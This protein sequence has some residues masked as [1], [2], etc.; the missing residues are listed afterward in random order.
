MAAASL[1]WPAP[2]AKGPGQ[3][4]HY[5]TQKPAGSAADVEAKGTYADGK[6]TVEFKRKLAT[7]N[8]DDAAFDLS[9]PVA[10]AVATF[11]S[12]EHS[13]HLVSGKLL[14]KFGK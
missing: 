13:E 4:P 14:L 5:A 7:G 6:W 12:N 9:K 1:H 11:D 8:K 2:K 3:A 10:F